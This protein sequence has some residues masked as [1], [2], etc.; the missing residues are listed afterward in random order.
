MSRVP[1]E[2]LL[3]A[4]QRDCLGDLTRGPLLR[5]GKYFRGAS[6]YPFR[7]QTVRALLHM[8]LAAFDPDMGPRG[9]V[10]PSARTIE[11]QQAAGASA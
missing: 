3:T 1:L 4:V 11:A 5:S 9:A 6:N 2:N 10:V 7:L 8:R